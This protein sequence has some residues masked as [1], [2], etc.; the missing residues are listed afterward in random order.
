MKDD[1]TTRSKLSDVGRW[2]VTEFVRE[3]SSELPR[4]T[5]LLDAGAGEGHYRKF[6]S[7]C[8]YKSAD[9][10]VGDSRWIYDDLDYVAPLDA[11]P[12]A[13]ATFD[14]VLCTQVLEHLERPFESVRE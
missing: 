5:R 7:H 10:G 12:V 8:D 1:F 14:A 4:G 9:L 11:L 2:Y 6:F 3:V 13:D